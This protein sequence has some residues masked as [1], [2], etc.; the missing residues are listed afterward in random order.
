[1]SLKSLDFVGRNRKGLYNKKSVKLIRKAIALVTDTNPDIPYV[2]YTLYL[3]SSEY[4]KLAHK[5]RLKY[6]RTLS[7]QQEFF[8]VEEFVHEVCKFLTDTEQVL[9]FTV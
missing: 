7:L 8:G 6:Y 3:L 5:F 2:L 9:L 1:M 4:P